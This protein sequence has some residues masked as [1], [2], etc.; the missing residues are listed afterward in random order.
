M[1]HNLRALETKCSSPDRMWK[2]GVAGEGLLIHNPAEGRLNSIIY[3]I[4]GIKW[5]INKVSM[6]SYD[7]AEKV[8]VQNTALISYRHKSNIILT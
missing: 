5:N 3:R 4:A 1:F 7:V 6:P 2:P 8:C